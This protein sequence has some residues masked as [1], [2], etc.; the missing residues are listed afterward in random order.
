MLELYQNIKKY[1]LANDWSQSELAR[2]VGY[3]DKSMI[4]RIENGKVDLQLN[5]IKAFADVF[6][7]TASELMGSD[8]IDTNSDDVQQ[9]VHSADYYL[10]AE[11]AKKAQEL[12]NDKDLRVLFDAARGSRPED[13]QMA[14]DLLRRLK[15]TNPDG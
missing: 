12:F 10:D 5:Q 13:L 2:R 4:S 1:R 3:A 15:E 8:G 7:I 9:N 11:T 6:G 14:A